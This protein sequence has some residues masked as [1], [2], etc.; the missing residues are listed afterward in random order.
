MKIVG[1]ISSSHSN[2]NT[3]ALVREA[4]KG[5]E[6]GGASVTEIFLPKYNLE[7]CNG[8]LKCLEDKCPINDDFEEVRD[9]IYQTDGIIW[10]SP[11]FGAAPNAIMKNL[12]DR[13]G[14]FERFTSSLGG[15]YVAGISTAG[16]MGAKKVSKRL[17]SIAKDGIFKRGYVS[18]V[19]GVAIGKGNVKDD[20][21]ALMK[22]YNLGK[23]MSNDIKTD[24][25][26]PLQNLIGRLINSIMIKPHFKKVILRDKETN[27][28]AVY[29]NLMQRGLV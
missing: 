25:K 29:N 12:I 15:K 26:Y 6:E 5:A 20:S 1:I 18:G 27:M 2:G 28:K 23:K 7:F 17:V 8:C 24:N 21:N 19:L 3:A 13:L 9:L 4:L 10:S 11:T 22:A 14:M 16:N